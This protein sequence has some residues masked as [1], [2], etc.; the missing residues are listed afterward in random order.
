[1]PSFSSDFTAARAEKEEKSSILDG[2]VDP[3]AI[4]V[5]EAPPAD[6]KLNVTKHPHVPLVT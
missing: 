1:M 2:V 4:K 6:L 3:T 5:Q